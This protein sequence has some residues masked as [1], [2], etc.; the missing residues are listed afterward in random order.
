MGL[1]RCL[2]GRNEFAR[3]CV[4]PRSESWS[5][6]VRLRRRF[7]TASLLVLV[8]VDAG[9]DTATGSAAAPIASEKVLDWTWL[10]MGRARKEACEKV[11]VEEDVELLSKLPRVVLEELAT[12]LAIVEMLTALDVC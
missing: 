12:G 4:L 5:I 7:S 1:R 11:L 10:E 6:S 9:A 3:V 2:Y 8:S